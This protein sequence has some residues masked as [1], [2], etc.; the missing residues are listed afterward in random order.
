MLLAACAVSVVQGQTIIF[1]DTFS[2]GTAADAGY[3][4]FGT[5]G[6]T[7]ARDSTNNELDFTMGSTASSRSGVIKSF[8]EQTLAVNDSIIFSFSI[9]SRSLASSQNHAF[10]WAI[11]NLGNGS[12]VTGVPVTGDFTSATPFGSGARE[13]YQFSA[14]TSSTAGFGQFVT[15]SSSP[16][17]NQSG[18]GTAIAS[19]AG[20]ASVAL[21]G[22]T[23]VSLTITRTAASNYSFSQTAFGSTTSGTL[24][25]VGTNIFNNL[26]FSFN[27][28]PGTGTYDVALD[29][30]QVTVV[31]EP[32]TWALLA[33]GMLATVVFRRRRRMA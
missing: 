32:S 24:T 26:A 27:N 8:T 1:T 21:T 14:S 20:P 22:A 13:M 6:T 9:N 33:G 12:A 15:G 23:T 30:I 3:Y 7:L 11:G 31:P 18:T 28:A 16:V 29:N 4:R 19:F 25:G 10:R 5:T 2:S 17:H